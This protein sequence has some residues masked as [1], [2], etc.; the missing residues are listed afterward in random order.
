[1][2]KG[3]E[4]KVRFSR[5]NS[6]A[7]KLVVLA[8]VMV[9]CCGA[10]LLI[11]T[12]GLSRLND[13]IDQVHRIQGDYLRT[14]TDLQAQCYTTQIFVLNKA[15]TAASGASGV[16]TAAK[17]IVDSLTGTAKSGVGALQGSKNLPIAQKDLET[18][19]GSFDDYMK[20]LDGMVEALDKGKAETVAFVNAV[21]NS[22]GPMN[23]RLLIMLA[24]LRDAG[25]SASRK[26]QS[27]SQST[28]LLLVAVIVASIIVN[29]ILS[30]L[31]MRSITKPLGSLVSAVGRIGKGDFTASTGLKGRD[32]LGRIAESLDCLVLNLREL[33]STAK[34]RLGLLEDSG[35]GLNSMMEETGASV[36][37]INA[38]IRSTSLQLKEQTA[39]VTEV[40][41]AIEEL[42]RSVDALGKMIA[43]QS[44]V[45]SQSSAAVEEMIASVE[46]VASRTEAAASASAA[47][48]AEGNEG[49]ARID[50][51]GESVSAIVRYSENL[52][53][54]AALIT[55][56]AGRTNLL[57]MNAAIEAAHAGDSGKGFAVVSDEIRKLAEQSTAQAKDISADLLRVSGAIDAVRS[58]S[59]AAVGSFSSILGKSGTLGEAIREMG[60]SMA[61]QREGGRQVLEGLARLRDIT[62]EIERGSGEM[63]L[64]NA[65]ILEQVQKL[66]SVNAAV[67]GNNAEM[68]AGTEEI[69]KAIAGTVDLSSKTAQHIADVKAAMDGFKI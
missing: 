39:A 11:S 32:E 20:V 69:N 16:G 66:T 44:S 22:F 58:A 40:S 17:P 43:N 64:G 19:L 55:E 9:A 5:G 57:A 36:V 37:Q 63:G 68:S 46:S 50:D 10:I 2:A 56:I 53:Q 65:A 30:L 61:E 26:A 49:K 7:A 48:V 34:D 3:S 42:A 18:F 6:I 12:K 33:V 59:V 21:Q 14:C 25:D 67:V 27:L 47:L 13:S 35:L 28:S 45:I 51:V 4:G 31:T 38:N 1:M 41:A 52:G 24:S 8:V 62:R 54:A 15:L 23:N 29:V 60:G